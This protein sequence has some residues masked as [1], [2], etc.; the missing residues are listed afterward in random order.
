MTM[1]TARTAAPA[2]TTMRWSLAPART[3]GSAGDRATL[4]EELGEVLD[5]VMAALRVPEPDA[6]RR[7]ACDMLLRHVAS[8]ARAR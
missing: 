2:R 6:D 7:A 3:L 8:A 5:S 4:D 1:S